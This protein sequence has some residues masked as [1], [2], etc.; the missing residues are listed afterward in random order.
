MRRREQGFRWCGGGAF[1]A[2]NFISVL[3]PAASGNQTPTKTRFFME[4]LLEP[5]PAKIELFFMAGLLAWPPV[6]IDFHWQSV[7]PHPS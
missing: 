2:S 1:I 7:T 6:K 3:F 4:G 5:P